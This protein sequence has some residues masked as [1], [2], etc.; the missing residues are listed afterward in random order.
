VSEHRGMPGRK[1]LPGKIAGQYIVRMKPGQRARGLVTAFGIVP[2]HVYDDVIDGFA[3]RLTEQQARQLALHPHVESVEPD[4]IVE[5]E[6]FWRTQHTQQLDENADPWGLDRIDQLST[7]YT[8]TYRYLHTGKGVNVFVLDTGIDYA[9]PEFGGRARFGYDAF[10]GDG[11]DRDG[12]G[13]H[14]AGTIGGEK[15][16]VA[17]EVSLVSVKILDD[18]G[19][20]TW[21]G[22]IA[23]MDWVLRHR[24]EF[25]VANMSI[26]GGRNTSVNAA[27][28]K[29]VDEGVT[30]VVA[31]G[32]EA[33]D[34]GNVSPA[35]APEAITVGA[36]TRRD[37]AAWW[38]NFGPA[39]DIWA[40]GLYILSAIPG[41]RVDDYSGTSMACPHVAGV[42]ALYMEES[43]RGDPAG[44]RDWLLGKALTGRM[45][46]VRPDT[47]D[48]LL[49]KARL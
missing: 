12:H 26:G 28:K 18:N 31:A 8:G 4:G 11:R 20:G 3:A 46:R 13:T 14:V 30:V 7:R 40:P 34:A 35:S 5:T 15:Y 49:H 21:S 25:S 17:K 41:G 29:L 37:F 27:V 6:A 10:G 43:G 44:V 39:V 16:G 9:H 48:R 32:N 36:S 33:L 1:S 23:G 22:V 42:A 2:L 24:G 47:T 19:S 45:S 38:S